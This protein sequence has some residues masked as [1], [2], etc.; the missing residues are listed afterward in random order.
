MI[1]IQYFIKLCTR[2]NH[3]WLLYKTNK[4]LFSNRS[5]LLLV[6][7]VMCMVYYK[8]KC[9]SC[10]SALHFAPNCLL[11]L[12]IIMSSSSSSS[13]WQSILHMFWFISKACKAF[14]KKVWPYKNSWFGSLWYLEAQ[15]CLEANIHRTFFIQNLSLS[16][17]PFLL[18]PI[19]GVWWRCPN[20]T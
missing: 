9:S 3:Y 10:C 4:P 8:M 11:S 13:F 1:I 15:W 17:F 19:W 18:G 6:L 7:H 14:S 2:S 16:G 20:N 5:S 12:N